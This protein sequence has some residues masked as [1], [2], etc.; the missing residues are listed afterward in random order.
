M[1]SKN[2]VIGH[3]VLLRSV[4]ARMTAPTHH[5]KSRFFGVI[6][7]V[8]LCTVS[9]FISKLFLLLYLF[10]MTGYDPAAGSLLLA[11]QI[12]FS[13]SNRKMDITE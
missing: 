5:W 1:F 6:H 7:L 11:Y 8:P 10:T 4:K 13:Y 3:F 12:L 9:F 2:D